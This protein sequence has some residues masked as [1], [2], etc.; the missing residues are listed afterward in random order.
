MFFSK[1]LIKFWG[2]ST[3]RIPFW[4]FILLKHIVLTSFTVS[5]A[6]DEDDRTTDRFGTEGNS[7]PLPYSSV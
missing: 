2:K 1:I 7:K 6:L 5:I 3:E 4:S